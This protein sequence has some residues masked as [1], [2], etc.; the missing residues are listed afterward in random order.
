[1]D[2]TQNFMALAD[3]GQVECITVP[4]LKVLGIHALLLRSIHYR[5]LSRH[6]EFSGFR[7]RRRM[8]VIFVIERS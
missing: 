7:R 8:E 1:M 6:V 3:F 4:P 2:A 5:F